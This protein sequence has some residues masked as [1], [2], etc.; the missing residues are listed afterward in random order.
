MNRLNLFID[1]LLSNANF[2]PE[3]EILVTQASFTWYNFVGKSEP[4]SEQVNRMYPL[5]KIKNI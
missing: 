5:T 1:H 2:F 4:Q 3:Q